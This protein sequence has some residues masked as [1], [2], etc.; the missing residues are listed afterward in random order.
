MMGQIE[1]YQYLWKSHVNRLVLI[2][3][4]MRGKIDYYSSPIITAQVEIEE[5]DK[6]YTGIVD[7]IKKIVK[8][9]TLKLNLILK[10][11]KMM[12]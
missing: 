5:Y 3:T 4:M 9:E 8:S 6:E 11:L 12:L 1:E 2:R 7:S 10:K